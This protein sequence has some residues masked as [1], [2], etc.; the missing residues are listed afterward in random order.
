MLEVRWSRD[1]VGEGE[2]WRG[3]QV[4]GRTVEREMMALPMEDRRFPGQGLRGRG[5]PSS[6]RYNLRGVATVGSYQPG[7]VGFIIMV[8]C[9]SRA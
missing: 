7:D 9:G 8:Q 2:G 6:D 5:N 4:G 3:Q 1:C